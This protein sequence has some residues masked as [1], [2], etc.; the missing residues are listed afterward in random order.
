M[1]YNLKDKDMRLR[2]P[3]GQNGGRIQKAVD[4]R[5]YFIRLGEGDADD[6]SERNG[7]ETESNGE[8]GRRF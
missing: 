3:F 6:L 1:W 4:C 7:M 2:V 5:N 8:A